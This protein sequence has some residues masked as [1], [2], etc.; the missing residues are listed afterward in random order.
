[1]KLILFMLPTIFLVVYSQL[2]MKW[3]VESLA[4][5][6][7]NSSSGAANVLI[8]I[9]DPFIVSAYAAALLGS[10][11][12]ILVIQRYPVSLAFPVYVGMTVLLVVVGGAVLFNESMGASKILSTLLIVAGVVMATRA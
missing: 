7:R 1:M 4:G 8:Y 5:A 10:I 12:W 9:T 11:A 3:R 6:V 2:V